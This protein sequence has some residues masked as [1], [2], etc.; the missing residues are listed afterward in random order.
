[1]GD[2]RNLTRKVIDAVKR[3]LGESITYTPVGGIAA[4]IEAVIDEAY[5]SVDP[6]TGATIISEQ[7]VILV[8]IDD[9]PAVPQQYDAVSMRGG[10]YRVID[11]Q[12]DGQAAYR[13]FLHK[14]P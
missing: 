10:S 4:N 1:M 11:Y 7:P 6:N 12:T 13:I 3:T 9:L 14:A 2:W 5:E 8:K